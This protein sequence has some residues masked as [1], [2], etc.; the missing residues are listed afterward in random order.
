MTW[1]HVDE[2]WGRCAPLF[3][4]SIENLHWREYLHL[5]ERTAQALAATGPGY[6]AMQ[7]LG[8]E[9]FLA[10]T[11]E[12]AADLYRDGLGVRVEVEVQCLVAL[13]P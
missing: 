2:G 9:A 1:E 5:L 3:A 7:H 6:L 4:Y 12:A 11:R 10:T 8:A 13:V